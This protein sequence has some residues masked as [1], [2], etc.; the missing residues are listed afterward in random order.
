MKF[1]LTNEQVE[2]AKKL[3][4]EVNRKLHDT[5]SLHEILGVSP[6]SYHDLTML[7]EITNTLIMRSAPSYSKRKPMTPNVKL[8]MQKSN[9]L[10][11]DMLNYQ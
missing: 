11:D 1:E 4:T 9:I 7:Y 2:N 6:L 3:R 8:V 10:D 5:H